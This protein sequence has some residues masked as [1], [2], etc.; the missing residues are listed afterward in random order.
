MTKGWHGNPEG[1]SLAARGIKLKSPK[2]ER[3]ELKINKDDPIREKMIKHRQRMVDKRSSLQ[4]KLDKEDT[5]F[6]NPKKVDEL[7]IKIHILNRRIDSVE[8]QIFSGEAMTDNLQFFTGANWF[9]PGFEEY[10]DYKDV[11]KYEKDLKAKGKKKKKFIVQPNTRNIKDANDLID[12]IYYRKFDSRAP[13]GFFIPP[14]REISRVLRNQP[15]PHSIENVDLY[16]SQPQRITVD[17]QNIRIIP[18][19]YKDIDPYTKRS[20]IIEMYPL[21]SSKNQSDLF[22]KAISH[23]V[24]HNIFNNLNKANRKEYLE[25]VGK[26]KAKP[27][28]RFSTSNVRE[29]FSGNYALFVTGQKKIDDKREKYFLDL[30]KKLRVVKK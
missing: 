14:I 30:S 17:D 5:E 2:T 1:H 19:L 8:V 29:D 11:Y 16:E 15:I 4:A 3:K 28:T 26:S 7:A 10:H 12:D 21:P 18:V 6:G 27:V 25:L 24:G 22:E 20:S 9:Q 13:A 23:E